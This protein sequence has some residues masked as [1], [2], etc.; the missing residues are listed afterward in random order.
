MQ[1][2]ANGKKI[3]NATLDPWDLKNQHT[4]SKQSVGS[5]PNLYFTDM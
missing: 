2:D 4:P 1:K 3:S 5:L